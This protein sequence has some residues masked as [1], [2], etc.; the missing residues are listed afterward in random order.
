MF[1]PPFKGNDYPRWYRKNGLLLFSHLPRKYYN[2][3]KDKGYS[4]ISID[5]TNS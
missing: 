5:S 4:D 3:V 1:L 2:R